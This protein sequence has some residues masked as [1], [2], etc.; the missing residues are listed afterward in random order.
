MR[1][2][3]SLHIIK[4]CEIERK[5]RMSKKIMFFDID[6]T[7][8]TQDTKEVPRS[9]I[10]A[11]KEARNKGHLTFINTGRTYFNIDKEIRDIGFDGYVCGCGTYINTEGKVIINVTLEE[12]EGYRIIE[13]LRRYKIDA[14][15][16]GLNDVYFDTNLYTEDMK[17]IKNNFYNIGYGIEKNWDTRGFVYDKLFTKASD[18]ADIEGFI[19]ELGEEYDYI[20]R[21]NRFGEIMP[22]GYSKASGIKQ[23]LEHYGLGIEDAYVFGDSSNDL[24]MF[25][26][27]PN[28]IAMGQSDECI[29]K[30]A[31]YIT[32]NIEDNGIFH[33][34][35][36]FGII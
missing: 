32:K 25:E 14:V 31:S 13:L 24:A 4:L 26:Y 1:G 3:S 34:M 10:E 18:E 11:I 27:V 21:G 16:E 7:I 6:G 35:K 19:H 5:Y 30:K 28:S 29:Y 8:L 22:K 2:R 23:L 20:D 33:A 9:T 17:E 36:H 15:L 12:L